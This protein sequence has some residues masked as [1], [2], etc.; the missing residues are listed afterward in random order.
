MIHVM[1]WASSLGHLPAA[2]GAKASTEP[3]MDN[4]HL[5]GERKGGC[6]VINPVLLMTLR[7][8]II[9]PLPHPLH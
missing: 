2:L 9:I 3:D 4:L 6:L 8:F 5:Q 7:A 1:T